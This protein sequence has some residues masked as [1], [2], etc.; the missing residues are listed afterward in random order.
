MDFTLTD[1]QQ[2][3][4]DAVQRFVR[5]SYD[6]EFR[7][8][9]LASAEGFSRPTWKGLADLGAL[10]ILVPEDQGGLAQ[11][12]METALAMMAAGPALL[13]EPWLECAVTASVLL[14]DFGDKLTRAEL[15]PLM[16]TGE[17]I[18][19]LAHQEAAGR[20]DAAWVETSVTVQGG[21][22]V[23]QGHKAVV[24]GASVADEWLVSARIAGRPQDPAGVSLYRV[25]R[26]TP[27]VH[28]RPCK[29]I[30]GRRAA[31]FW[32][33]G[34]RLPATH[35]VGAAGQALPAIEQALDYT[36]AAVCA[37]AVGVMQATVDATVEYLKTRRQFGQP[38]G[39]FQAL[40]HR[41]VDMLVHL[42]Q[43][44]SMMW[45]AALRCTEAHAATRQQALAA[46]KV[47]IGQACR[48]ISQQAM[49]LHG[50]IGMSDELVLSHWFKRLLAIELAFGGTDA[51]LRRFIRLEGARAAA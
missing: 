28:L 13:I 41:A 32:L 19:V 50:G 36:L 20:G 10:A 6:F 1:E 9:V 42:E 37:E 5:G 39:R 18:V 17:R 26:G 11:G 34:V 24:G 49:Q 48:F 21:E 40:Q 3:L 8:K 33:Q 15:L 44:R 47:V 2:Q 45:L 38:I 29:T 35:C 46:A 16:V 30:D 51:Q 4:Q 23:L 22:H 31:E 7:K 25:P 12:P 43:A 27:G 14:R